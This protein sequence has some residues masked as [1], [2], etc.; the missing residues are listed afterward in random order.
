MT[1]D[2]LLNIPI[3]LWSCS[4]VGEERSGRL[5]DGLVLMR[6][7]T[8]P[9]LWLK[10]WRQSCRFIGQLLS[11][12]LTTSCG[13][14][15]IE[16]SINRTASSVG[17]P[18]STIKRVKSSYGRG[19]GE[20]HYHR[21][22]SDFPSGRKLQGQNQDMLMRFWHVWECLWAESWDETGYLSRN[23]QSHKYTL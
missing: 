5:T 22:R 6:S 20:S 1:W 19:A 15:L 17:G 21:F 3:V 4:S 7:I 18:D 11:S 23:I 14:W 12:C 16:D 9:V 8:G 2:G 10:A 13:S